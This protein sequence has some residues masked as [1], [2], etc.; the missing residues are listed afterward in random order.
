MIFHDREIEPLLSVEVT[1][2]APLVAVE[3]RGEVDMATAETLS[4][5]F[6]Y[7]VR[8]RPAR[9]SVSLAGVTFFSAAGV[10]ALLQL[11]D[12]ARWDDIELVLGDVSEPAQLVLELVRPPVLPLSEPL[13]A[14][15]DPPQHARQ[16]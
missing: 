7:A 5:A 1:G 16:A 14:T 13:G 3:V 6:A 12:A 10:R 15:A 11:R 8:S 2:T 4:A 9:V